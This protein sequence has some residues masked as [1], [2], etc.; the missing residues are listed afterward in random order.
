MAPLFDEFDVEIVP[1]ISS[2]V[3]FCGRLGM[4]YEDIN[5]VSLHGR[6]CNIVS[7]VR[8]HEKN[9]V[10]LGENPCRRLTEFNLGDTKVYIG[11]RLSYNDE[12]IFSGRARDFSDKELNPLSVMIIENPNFS[13]AVR[14][15]INDDE[16]IRA[17]VPMTKSEV[18]SVSLSKLCIKENDICW[19]IG[20]GTGSV[21]VEMALLCRRG[22]V[23]A[24]EKNG[25]AAELIEENC[26]KF[27]TDNVCIIRGNAPQ[28]LSDAEAPSKVFIGG[29]SGNM[30]G[31]IEAAL[32]KNVNAR[33]VINAIAL[34]TALGTL[35]ILKELNMDF[36][37]SQINAARNK[38]AGGLNLMCGLNPV[39]VITAKRKESVT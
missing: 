20:A 24:V 2:L 15:G 10:L 21:T 30:R 33:F 38:K 9:F 31:I 22:T 23:Y 17:D 16:F 28:C 7:E 27:M 11:E 5:T 6:K 36:E 39:F 8:T 14:I 4:S 26:K 1:G 34:E 18:R 25:G 29:S 13:N 37:V 19:D 3:Y 32:A 12:R 35:N